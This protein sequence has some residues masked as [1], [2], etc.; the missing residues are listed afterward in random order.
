M[1]RGDPWRVQQCRLHLFSSPG[2]TL[3]L[4]NRPQPYARAFSLT[5]LV[6]ASLVAP[7]TAQQDYAA[8]AARLIS[9]MTLEEKASQMQNHSVAIPRL[10]IPEYDWW[11]EGLHGTARSGYATLFP[12]AIGMAATWDPALIGEVGT[13][14][15]TEARAKYNQ[16]LRED[17]HSIYYGLTI[18]SP[19][20][21]IFR[22]PRWGRGQETYGEDPFL[23]GT[24]GVAFIHG[25]QGDDPHYLRAIGTPKHFAVHSGP[26]SERHRFNVN[27]SAHDLEDT[28]LPAFRAAITEG[29]AQSI[30]C[31]YNAVDG[32]AACANKDLLATTLR[33]NWHFSGFVTS[34]CGAVSDISEFHKLSPDVEH[35]SASSLLAGTDTSCG[36]EYATLPKAVRDGL[37]KESEVDTALT[38]L[39]VARFQLG[40][41]DPQAQVPYAATPVTELDSAAHRALA[42]RTAHEAIVL[43]KNESHTLPL[44]R[45][46]G[47]V[48]VVGPNA[49]SLAALEGNY[50]AIPS[51]PVTPLDG[52]RAALPGHVLYAQGAPYVDGL[53]VPAP[54]TLFHPSAG[55]S[56]PG[57]HADYYATPD[58]SGAAVLSRT[59]SHIDFDWNA[60]SPAPGVQ[61]KHFSVRWSGTLTPPA[62]GDYTF[63]ATL[64]DC[65]PCN[66]AATYSVFVDDRKLI[67]GRTNPA[68]FSRSR[69]NA[70][71]HVH[72]DDSRPHSFRLEYTHV[73]PLFGAGITLNWQP[74]VAVLRDEAV[75]AARK[76]DA[77]VAFIG[78]S[79]DLEGEEMPVKVPGFAGG[80]RTSLDLPPAQQ[81]LLEAVAS[82]GKP[83]IVVLMNGSA[84]AV[85]WAQ[86][87]AA[88]V[89]EAWY[90]GEAGGEAIADTLTGSNNPAGRLPVTFY[91]SVAQLP[92]FD[93]YSMKERTYRYSH[94]QPL[95]RFGDGLS[96]SSFT[97]A[98]TQLSS[99]SLHAGDTLKVTTTVTNTG[100]IAGDEVVEAYLTPPSS[101]TAPVRAL[102]GFARVH[103]APKESRA[104]T[105]AIA[106]RQLSQVSAAG[107]RAVTAGAYTLYVGS[108]QPDAG[109]TGLPFTISGTEALPR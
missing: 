69:V 1:M 56:T 103:L 84:L 25:L 19:N 37:V 41:F 14:V 20:I 38:R 106:P 40:M 51:H 24:L 12:Q 49:A 102:V 109:D 92:P 17:N 55:S 105:L 71:F 100:V 98:G 29:H 64:V 86:Q 57:L 107:E 30:M 34:D 47:T 78:L 44:A 59:D 94:A 18:W 8:R 68:E 95:Y 13:V 65:Y 70:S 77:V 96:Y 61:L 10:G 15:S 85:N 3:L 74:P 79:P 108:N 35:A 73:T 32:D 60:A 104:V 80:D 5:L 43:L 76:A 97:Y 26:E 99:T 45:G 52:L 72:F 90:P 91:A 4:I 48:A 9:Q 46:I 67:E 27:P 6:A 54:E 42:L 89:L 58:L 11:N 87:H 82:T 33:G 50:N 62:P 22:D 23:T 28:Y 66:D 2:V 31:A 83:L 75:A 88:A 101:Q 16:A 39:F 93:D 63:A 7:A 21:N 53:N 81:Q 36:T